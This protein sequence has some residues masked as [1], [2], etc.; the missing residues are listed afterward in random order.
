MKKQKIIAM[1]LVFLTV[2]TVAGIV[3]ANV[4]TVIGAKKTEAVELMNTTSLQ[5]EDFLGN[6]IPTNKLKQ[7]Q[8]L[9]GEEDKLFVASPKCDLES[10]I[11]EFKNGTGEIDSSSKYYAQ[12]EKIANGTNYLY[13]PFKISMPKNIKKIR[14]LTDNIDLLLGKDGF[15]YIKQN[16]DGSYDFYLE[17]AFKSGEYWDKGAGVQEL[18]KELVFECYTNTTDTT[19]VRTSNVVITPK[20]INYV[21]D[22]EET[23]NYAITKEGKLIEI[24]TVEANDTNTYPAQLQIPERLKNNFSYDAKTDTVTMNNVGQAGKNTFIIISS[25]NF[26]IKGNN[27]ID[28]EVFLTPLEMNVRMDPKSVLD[29]FL[30]HTLGVEVNINYEDMTNTTYIDRTVTEKGY[31]I[32]VMTKLQS[33][34]L[35]S[36]VRKSDWYYNA[37]KYV[38]EHKI[39]SGT[40]STTFASNQNLTRGMIVTM[41]YNMENHP[42]IKGTSKFSDVQNK[43][44]YFYNAVVWASNNNVVSGYANGKFGP[45]DNITREQLATI[46][47]NYCRYKGKYKTVHA[48]YSKFTDSSKISSFAKWGMNWAVGHKIVNGSNGKLN[49]Q[50][51]ATRAEAAAMISNYCNTIK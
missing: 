47:Y 44:V 29:C 51:T 11:K 25:K 2:V 39:M 19:P 4:P 35:F 26:Y 9:E 43:N 36:D 45:D 21:A 32:T 20:D 38:Y 40:N 14:L 12:L 24:E 8:M 1:I 34:K 22:T 31:G 17:I 13:L 5:P 23:R 33:T 41:L 42:S 7:Y 18:E 50:G 6:I 30:T 27:V 46:L 3:N 15:N 28:G 48:D 16:S 37:V 49:P 10:I